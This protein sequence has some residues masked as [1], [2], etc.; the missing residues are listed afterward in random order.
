MSDQPSSWRAITLPKKTTAA[1]ETSPI[2]A[3]MTDWSHQSSTSF[4]ARLTACQ[5]FTYLRE[6]LF[7]KISAYRAASSKLLFVII[8]P[9]FAPMLAHWVGVLPRPTFHIIAQYSFKVNVGLGGWGLLFG[10]V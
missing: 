10:A 8:L 7:G 3:W 5:I 1:I 4:E 9:R 6:F 2:S